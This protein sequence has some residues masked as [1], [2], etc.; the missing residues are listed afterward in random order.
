MRA[1]ADLSDLPE[2]DR[3]RAIVDCVNAGNVVAVAVDDEAEKIARYIRRLKF[4]GVRYMETC[5]GLVP[6]T[7]IIKFGPKLDA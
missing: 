1:Y 5:P 3:L 6:E 2:A 7:V 4:R